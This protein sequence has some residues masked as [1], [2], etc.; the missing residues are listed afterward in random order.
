M[1]TNTRHETAH[2]LN[3]VLSLFVFKYRNLKLKLRACVT[4]VADELPVFWAKTNAR[5]SIRVKHRIIDQIL[6]MHGE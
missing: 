1:L 5:S 6:L 2:L 3:Q 4:L